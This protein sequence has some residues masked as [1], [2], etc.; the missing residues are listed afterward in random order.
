MLGVYLIRRYAKGARAERELAKLLK[1]HSFSVIRAAGS[2][3]SIS[4][5]D[6]VAI[7][8]NKI[9]AF[10]CKAWKSVPRLRK[11][12]LAEFYRWCKNAGAFGFLA[13]RNKEWLFLDIKTLKSGGKIKKEGI[14]LNDLLYVFNI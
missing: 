1:K 9:L 13:W 7:K 12:E 6:L 3:G 10:E 11:E 14:N 2:G 4:T 8:N 5:P